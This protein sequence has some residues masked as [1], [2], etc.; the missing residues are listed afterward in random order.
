[1]ANNNGLF[2]DE[3]I[4]IEA[5]TVGFEKAKAQVAD[6]QSA[7]SK[8][9]P[10]AQARKGIKSLESVNE[11]L[12]SI[13]GTIEKVSVAQDLMTE[14][15]KTVA[16]A[17]KDY[18][19]ILVSPSA[20]YVEKQDAQ[21]ALQSAKMMYKQLT[22]TLQ[23]NEGLQGSIDSVNQQDVVQ[24]QETLND[25]V[26]RQAENEDEIAKYK[27]AQR[28]IG[29]ILLEQEQARVKEE[30]RLAEQQR[31]AQEALATFEMSLDPVR[32]KLA[33][34][35]EQI[36]ALREE[37]EEAEQAFVSSMLNGD[38][39]GLDRAREKLSSIHAQMVKLRK[40]AEKL[41]K[42]AKGT[43]TWWQKLLGRIRN[44][45]IYRAIRRVMQLIVNAM[46]E[47]FENMTKLS[48]EASNVQKSLETNKNLI[49]SALGETLVR[50]IEPLM[51][52]LDGIVDVI[53]AILNYLN[54]II[55]VLSGADKYTKI[56][57]KDAQKAGEA[58][59]LLS[60]DKFEALTKS[61]DEVTGV[62]AEEHEISFGGV[63]G[64]E[65]LDEVRKVIREIN[66]GVKGMFD[67]IAGLIEI[68]EGDFDHAWEHI[69][70]GFLKLCQGIVNVFVR[71]LNAIL[72]NFE[73]AINFTLLPV[74]LIGRLFGASE[75]FAQITLPRIPLATFA[76]GYANGGIPDKSELF[77][78]N[79]YGRPEALVNTG[80]TQTN[81]INLDQISQ[82]T[83]QGFVQAIYDTGLLSVIQ[84]SG[85]NGTIVVDG[86]VLG[87]TV[88]QSSGF[89]NEVNRR[90]TS[91][92]LR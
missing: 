51:P 4:N 5:R 21:K 24:F 82:A 18:E 32:E 38:N 53:V 42:S 26:Q 35:Y 20:S 13:K 81:V 78:M 14:S 45:A 88:A 22:A 76:N 27:I 86:N 15:A 6:L 2:D 66:E 28:L 89:R 36:R 62:E 77:Y 64:W 16:K 55:A 49:T 57:R 67:F 37:Q 92:N 91:L 33:K 31:K 85:G 19:K 56:L 87:R 58:L 68:F 90:N 80:G 39:G 61:T 23:R 30:A 12:D 54:I 83:H 1:M 73:D 25:A 75:D 3:I 63:L 41:E 34:V 70:G 84:E 59:G 40:E 72:S 8:V 43:Q 44:I 46:K 50:I 65:S 17:Q 60:F 52:L 71:L 10:T 11:A 48:E 7:L 9:L 47:G 29:L 74:N 69:K 79:E